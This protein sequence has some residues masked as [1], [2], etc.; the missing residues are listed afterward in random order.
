MAPARMCQRRVG[1][2]AVLLLLSTEVVGS[3][4]P[5][6]NLPT[7]GF[8]CQH[9]DVMVCAS[10]RTHACQQ[11]CRPASTRANEHASAQAR[12]RASVQARERASARA[13]KRA[14][15]RARRLASPQARRHAARA[16]GCKRAGAQS[17]SLA[18]TLARTCA[19]RHACR[20]ARMRVHAHASVEAHNKQAGATKLARSPR[21]LR[22]GRP[23]LRA[24]REHRQRC[25]SPSYRTHAAG[26][27]R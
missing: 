27:S 9:A 3:A 21:A 13:R 25:S 19:C 14:R 1:G 5:S 23:S 18:H 11:A 22:G 20:H 12:K 4:T 8:E 10:L 24:R 26:L 17:P 6:A 7:V 2:L 15:A 16:H